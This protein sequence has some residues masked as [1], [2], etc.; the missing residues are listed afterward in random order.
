MKRLKQWFGRALLAL[1]VMLLAAALAY[2]FPADIAL[3]LAVD[4]GT[5]V[6]AAVAVY[7]TARFAKIRPLIAFLRAHLA[8][9]SARSPRQP[10]SRAVAAQKQPC[11]DDEHRPLAALAA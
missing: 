1:I 3:L 6:E 8:V 5:W 9:R 11:N 10:R 4:L 7:V 2:S